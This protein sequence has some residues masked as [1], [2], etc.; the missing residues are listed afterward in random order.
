MLLGKVSPWDDTWKGV[1]LPG[2]K[3]STDLAFRHFHEV[4]S[5]PAFP[6]ERRRE[7]S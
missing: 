3:S 6:G 1:Y 2:L 7:E 5:C 4:E